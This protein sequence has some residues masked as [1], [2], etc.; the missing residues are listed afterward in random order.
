MVVSND[1]KTQTNADLP[2]EALA[3]DLVPFHF[4]SLFVRTK[5]DTAATT[6]SAA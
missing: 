2:N 5:V 4:G 6:P 1:T 3:S